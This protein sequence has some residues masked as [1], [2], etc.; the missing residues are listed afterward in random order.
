VISI[1]NI[2]IALLSHHFDDLAVEYMGYYSHLLNAQLFIQC[3]EHGNTHFLKEALLFTAFDKNIFRDEQVIENLLEI[4][5]EGY[6][7]NFLMNIL[8]LIDISV[9]KNK[10]MKELI[11]ILNEYAE[12]P[13]DKNKLLLS[14]NPLMTIALA[15]YMLDNISDA[16]KKFENEC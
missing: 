11:D 2:L 5:K 15:A 12:D 16:R 3:I 10:Y 8:V 1:D 9:W 14:P 6:R 4:M 13:Y 7:A